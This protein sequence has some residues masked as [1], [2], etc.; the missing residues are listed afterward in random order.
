MSLGG[1]GRRGGAHLACALGDRLDDVVI[2]G[3][4]AD[5]AFEPVADR[6]FVEMRAFAI[7][8]VDRGHDHAGGAKPALEAMIVLERLLHRVQPAADGEALDR[9][10]LRALAARG[11]NGAGLDGPAVDMDDAGA[12]LR[13]I[14]ADMSA[15]QAQVLAQDFFLDLELVIVGGVLVVASAAAGEMR[16]G[17]RDAV[18][19][20]FYDCGGLGA[21]EAGFFF[22]ECGFD[23]FSSKNKRNENGF[24]AAAVFITITRRFGGE[25]S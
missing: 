12:A 20:R 17:G 22:S 24:A 3:A 14:A 2:A 18:R 9:R 11:Q 8:E 21:G 10:H 25:A 4:A 23:L 1:P 5:V 13:R 6:G 16:A 15:G 19:G 7:D